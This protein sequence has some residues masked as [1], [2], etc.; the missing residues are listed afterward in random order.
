MVTIAGPAWH[1]L[2][3]NIVHKSLM[4]T[5]VATSSKESYHVDA[6]RL[7]NAQTA[8]SRRLNKREVD[9]RCQRQAR[10][11]KRSR[12]AQ[13]ENLVES[14]RQQNASGQV[15]AL[16]KQLEKTEEE[17]DMMT[18]TLRDIEQIMGQGH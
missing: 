12:V 16:L 8:S 14:L 11:R 3:S 10:E 18:K 4:A 2:Y 15:A 6:A 5:K 7:N 9:R 13:L 17:R 1:L